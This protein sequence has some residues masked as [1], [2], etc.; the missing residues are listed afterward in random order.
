MQTD[1]LCCFDI[2]G[3]ATGGPSDL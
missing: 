3:W 2:V 1:I